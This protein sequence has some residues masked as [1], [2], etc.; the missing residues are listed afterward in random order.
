MRLFVAVMM[1]AGGAMAQVQR[2]ET[3]GNLAPTR[4]PGCLTM[5]E[6]SPDETPANLALGIMRCV[7][8]GR[9]GAAVESIILMQLFAVY[10]ARRVADK[11]AHQAG[12]V[13]MMNIYSG[14][15]E[16]QQKSLQEAVEAFGDTGGA[17]HTALCAQMAGQGP[18]RYHPAYMIQHG[19]AAFTG[20]EG[21]GLVPG[22][23]AGL[24]W[25][26]VLASYLKCS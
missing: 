8:E 2:F 18:P 15:S 26:D 11:S 10:D 3:P 19:M 6:V 21:D 4:D 17:K 9:F 25:S 20:L 14:L 22:F 1:V 12:Q 5:T 24:A 7:G 13:L 23:D 16:K